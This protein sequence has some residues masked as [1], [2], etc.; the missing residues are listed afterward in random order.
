MRSFVTINAGHASIVG[1]M[2]MNFSRL[3]PMAAMVLIG[4]LIHVAPAL[5]DTNGVA[6][7]ARHGQLKAR[8]QKVAQELNLTPEQRQQL[9]PILQDAAQKLK[10]L[11]ADASLSQAQKHQQLKAIH[12]EAAAKIKPILT[13]EQLAK[14]QELRHQAR[15][16]RKGN[17]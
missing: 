10:A 11:R 16:N 3:V 8:V 6:G 14:W 17:T 9:K 1:V 7:A 12:Q 4:S 15:A 2:I 13:P 5:A